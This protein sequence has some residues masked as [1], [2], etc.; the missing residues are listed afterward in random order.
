[1]CAFCVRGGQK[2]FHNGKFSEFKSQFGKFLQKKSRKAKN[3]LTLSH[4]SRSEF[5]SE[6]GRIMWNF[7]NFGHTCGI[8]MDG[9]MPSYLN[10]LPPLHRFLV[11][12][13]SIDPKSEATM[14]YFKSRAA[15]ANG[16]K[17]HIENHPLTIHP[18]SRLK[19]IWE[20]VMAANFLTGLIYGPL[21][22]LDYIDDDETTD[23]GNLT[24]IKIVK[25][26][27]VMDMIL[28]FFCGYVDEKE[29]TVSA[30]GKK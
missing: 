9:D 25:F 30:G 7:E 6:R 18:F 5:K 28:R 24:L 3:F 22:Y 10:N 15:I 26:V 13:T 11:K 14:Q 23:I 27:C 21:Q 29:F 12:W 16:T 4:I 20:L 19:L 2:V 17:F 1:M 8:K